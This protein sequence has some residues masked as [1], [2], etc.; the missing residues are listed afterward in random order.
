LRVWGISRDEEEK[1]GISKQDAGEIKEKQ[2]DSLVAK[3]GSF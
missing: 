3:A 1:A 2:Q